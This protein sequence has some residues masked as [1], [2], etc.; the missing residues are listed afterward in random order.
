VIAGVDGC[1]SGWVAVLQDADGNLNIRVFSTFAE[2]IATDIRRIVIDVP[3]GIMTKE[4]RVVDRAAR[5]L[6]GERACCV[7]TAPYRAML[8]ARSHPDACSIRESIDGKRCSRQAFE[9]TA[10]IAEV[11]AL[12][13]PELQSRVR[14]GHPEITF[15]T[16]Q[17]G[18]PMMH[19]K[20][21]AAGRAARLAAL[22]PYFAEIDAV[23]S[24]RRPAGVAVDDLLDA[25]AMLWTARRVDAGVARR[26]PDV[27]GIDDQRD[28]RG[29]AAEMLA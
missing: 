17:Q 29:V 27:G 8:S 7:F 11:D 9:I 15:A 19:R 24:A 1:R 12:M 6:L 21:S 28:E 25:Y 14:E 2:M 22:H 5:K 23:V 13:T 18:L 20:K 16:M 10:K 26:L 4:P 3:I